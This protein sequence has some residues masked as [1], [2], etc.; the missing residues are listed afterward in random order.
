M[1]RRPPRST[2]FPYT[3]LFRSDDRAELRPEQRTGRTDVEAGSVRAVLADVGGHQPPEV[4]VLR[5]VDRGR[6]VD[7]PAVE[8]T[9]LGELVGDR[10]ERGHAQVDG[11]RR[12]VRLLD[13]RHV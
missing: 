7:R 8:G 5:P 1:I 9:A 4:G 6:L 10:A 13:E 11:H 3:T 2:L 12:L